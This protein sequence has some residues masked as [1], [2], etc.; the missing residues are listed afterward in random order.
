[1]DFK[2]NPLDPCRL[3]ATAE[4]VTKVHAVCTRTGNLANYSFRKTDNEKL[5]ML[6]ETEEYEPL[7]RAAYYHA[8]RK[9]QEENRNPLRSPFKGEEIERKFKLRNLKS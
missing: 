7:S 5:V 9:D 1:M 8:M 6:G 2:G 4:Y 3:M